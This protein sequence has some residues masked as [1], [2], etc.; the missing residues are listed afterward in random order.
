MKLGELLARVEQTE[1]H[2]AVYEELIHYLER[3]VQGEVEEL[4]MESGTG[5]VPNTRI[6][7]VQVQLRVQVAKLQDALAA[8]EEVEVG[9][10][11]LPLGE[12]T[13]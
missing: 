5:A 2:I 12:G 10:V 1:A 8:A 7:E 9:D 3:V 4:P 11:G 6:R 13:G